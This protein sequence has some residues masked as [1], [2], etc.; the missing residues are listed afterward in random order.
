MKTQ[1]SAFDFLMTIKNKLKGNR[2][3]KI[4]LLLALVLVFG[5]KINAQW[6][7]VSTQNVGLSGRLH[8]YSATLFLYG[9]FSGYHVYRSIDNGKTWT[10]I[11]SKFLYDV[12]YMF[13]Y[14]NEI[15]A[16]TANAGKSI[17]SSKDGGE[18]WALKS[19]IPTVT[20]NGAILWMTSDGDKLYAVSNRKS[21]YASTNNG[22][23][24]IETIINTTAGGNMSYFAASGNTMVSTIVGTGA[25]VSTDGGQTWVVN[26][27]GNPALFV[28]YVINF[29]GSVYGIT[30]GSGVHRFNSSTKTWESVSKG[31]PDALSFQISKALTAYGN[32]LYVAIIGFL[33]SKASIFSS[34]DNGANWN[35]ISTSGLTTLNAATSSS[36]LVLT[37]QNIF[38]YDYQSNGSTASVYKMTNST[39]SVN[40]SSPEVPADFDL[41]Q[42]YPN[43]FN[44][45]TTISYKVQAASNVS[46]KVYD[47]LG[48]EVA[49]L[50]DEFKQPGNYKVMFNVKT[51]YMASLP[52]GVYFYTLKAESF[53]E[54]KRMLLIK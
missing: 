49:T 21:F 46:L 54:T 38:L 43:P 7:K 40:E 39:T 51:P 2:C 6:E 32:S 52:S 4:K 50:V 36:S 18:T 13:N 42:N 47:I 31:L 48:N 35:S 10:D 23:T 16:L 53:S 37:A 12:Y 9:S 27:P 1:G 41:S 22:L 24:W 33:D 44:P 5:I 26:N 29:N 14:K 17:Y 11:I 8:A 30:S 20:G 19:S 28:T 45:E 25:V 15:F 34:S 3:M